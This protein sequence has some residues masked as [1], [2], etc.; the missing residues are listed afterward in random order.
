M[1]RALPLNAIRAFEAAGR[2]SSIT[3]AARELFVTP[4]AVSHQIKALEGYLGRPLFVRGHRAITLTSDGRRYLGEVSRHLDGLRRATA[5]LREAGD[6]RTVRVHAH[7]TIAVRWLIPRLSAFHAL[8]RNI[9]VKLITA[10][11]ADLEDPELDG[12]IRLGKGRWPGMR[13]YR[14]LANELVP[15]CAPAYRRRRPYL[16]S[17]RGLAK[18]TLLHSL[19]R[20]DD[21]ARWLAAMKVKE[22]DPGTGVE[23]ES[24]VL[25]YQAAVEGQGVA[26]AQKAL[27]ESD[28]DAGSLVY[29]YD[30]AI[31]MGAHTYYYVCPTDSR[32]SQGAEVFRKWLLATIDRPR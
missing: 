18:A 4:A 30:A 8:H 22:V 28:I 14:L 12:A 10:P 29:L 6:Y 20:R 26:I 17:P 7:A 3:K 5:K 13:A 15:V 1:A 9:D 27:V 32:R 25:A 11:D 24:S 31:D 23:Y 21:W 2:L 16:A 19:A